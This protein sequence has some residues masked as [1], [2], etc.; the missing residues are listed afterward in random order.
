[1]TS[2]Q[3]KVRREASGTRD[4]SGTRETRKTSQKTSIR[5]LIGRYR[6]KPA[7]ER[8]L[9]RETLLLNASTRFAILFLPFRVLRRMMGVQELNIREKG[10]QE[11]NIRDMDVQEP[12]IRDM[13][14]REL[15]LN[16]REVSLSEI[17]DAS[18]RQVATAILSVSR[19]V[20]WN[21][22]CLV[23]GASAMI[24]LKRRGIPAM[25]W[26]G[27]RMKDGGGMAP[28]AWVTSGRQVI[29]GGGELDTYTPVAVF[30]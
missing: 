3:D 27:V 5:S 4:I 22:T 15:A 14:I 1:M 21:A 28:H 13:G 29:L 25:L 26:L 2:D 23:Q 16:F 12:N 30:R 19:H 11:P 6:R 24:M 10:V 20:P 8:R 9:L 7:E 17:E 18:V